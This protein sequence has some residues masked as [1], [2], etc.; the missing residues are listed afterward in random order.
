MDL[1]SNFRSTAQTFRLLKVSPALQFKLTFYIEILW[2]FQLRID[3]FDAL[4]PF[5]FLLVSFLFFPWRIQ[6]LI[7]W[8]DYYKLYLNQSF[9]VNCEN[10][11]SHTS[12]I[13][14]T[15]KLT[16]IG[17]HFLGVLLISSNTLVTLGICFNSIW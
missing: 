7:I 1:F 14:T 17:K 13:F 8:Y 11:Q 9:D 6:L 2:I 16:Q 3:L 12:I 15:I 5:N 10:R 4:H